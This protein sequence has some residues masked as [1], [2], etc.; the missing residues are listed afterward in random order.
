[1]EDL[2]PSYFEDNVDIHYLT[3]TTLQHGTWRRSRYGRHAVC[4]SFARNTGY[5]SKN[6]NTLKV[7]VDKKN[8]ISTFLQS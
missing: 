6:V 8:V 2:L 5:H 1:M 4:C 3:E 7:I